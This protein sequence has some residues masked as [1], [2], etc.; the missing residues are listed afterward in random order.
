MNI[1][2]IHRVKITPTRLLFED[3]REHANYLNALENM[4]KDINLDD[5]GFQIVGSLFIADT[6]FNAVPYLASFSYLFTHAVN[7]CSGCY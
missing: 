1:A 3:I 6:T 5:V 2:Q 7:A 4:L